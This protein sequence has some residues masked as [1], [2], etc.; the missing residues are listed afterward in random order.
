MAPQTAS[1]SSTQSPTALLPLS[2]Q[3]PLR[4][5]RLDQ[6]LPFLSITQKNNQTKRKEHHPD[7]SQPEAAS[8][9]TRSAP[10]QTTTPSRPLPP[11]PTDAAA[12]PTSVALE[13]RA[14]RHHQAQRPRRNHT[15]RRP[16]Q[17][18]HSQRHQQQTSKPSPRP[19]SP[20]RPLSTAPRNAPSSCGS[21]RDTAGRLPSSAGTCRLVG[22]GRGRIRCGCWGFWRRW[23]KQ[24]AG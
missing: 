19:R 11:R 9:P 16:Q 7:A 17:H 22:A 12:N 24:R 14:C 2:S 23:R 1:G 4:H 13:H 8:Q 18:P 5:Q 20:K 21:T 3:P 15:P 10:T 6:H